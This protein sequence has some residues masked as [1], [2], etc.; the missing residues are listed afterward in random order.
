MPDVAPYLRL[1]R[2]G[3]FTVLNAALARAEQL[4][5]P[6]CI[7]VVDSGGHLLAFARMDGGRPFSND[8]AIAKAR[9]AVS[10]RAPTGGW[11]PPEVQIQIAFATQGKVTS[12]RGGLPLIVEGHM[13]GGVGVASGTPEHDYTVACAGVAALERAETFADPP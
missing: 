2:E 8:S 6:Q 9:T 12:L 3:A 11:R 10:D 4:D 7:A 13:I 1:T 5:V